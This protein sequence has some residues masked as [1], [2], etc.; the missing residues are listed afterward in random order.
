MALALL[1]GVGPACA[2]AA[3][4]LIVPGTR[5]G[6]VSLGLSGTQVVELLGEPPSSEPSDPGPTLFFDHPRIAVAL[7]GQQ[8]GNSVVDTVSTDSA[9]FADA[10]GIRVGSSSS[11]VIAAYGSSYQR[12]D[13]DGMWTL[14]YDDQGIRFEF[15]PGGDTVGAIEVYG[16]NAEIMQS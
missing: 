16:S 5:L 7:N 3:D 10:H 13:D 11:D 1:L 14:W 2:Q 15:E 4:Q 12:T 8:L 9:D 6:P